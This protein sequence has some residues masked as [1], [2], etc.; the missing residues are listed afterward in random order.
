M[1]YISDKPKRAKM[2]KTLTMFWTT[3]L[4]AIML[5]GAWFAYA[6]IKAAL[7]LNASPAPAPLTILLI[8]G[9]LIGFVRFVK[10]IRSG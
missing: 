9:G 4:I 6:D 10:Q 1:E 7:D 5:G 3:F 8:G 2:K